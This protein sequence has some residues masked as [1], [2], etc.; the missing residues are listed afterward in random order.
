MV[1]STKRLAAPARAQPNG[2][3]FT[4]SPAILPAGPVTNRVVSPRRNYL[5]ILWP[6]VVLHAVAMMYLLTGPQAPADL[7]LSD[8]T[9]FVGVSTNIGQVVVYS[10]ANQNVAVG[11]HRPAALPHGIVGAPGASH[12]SPRGK[13]SSVARIVEESG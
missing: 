4:W 2:I 1:E 13:R 7:F 8:E 5:E 6:V 3:G 9:M 11:S 12:R 10:D